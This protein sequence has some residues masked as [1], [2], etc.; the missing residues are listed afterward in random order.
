[1]IKRYSA[2]SRELADDLM[3]NN[4]GEKARRLQLRGA[5]EED[6]GGY[7]REKVLEYIEDH[8]QNAKRKLLEQYE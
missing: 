3:T 5:Q 2:F 6:Y 8:W 4:I 1:M 7:C